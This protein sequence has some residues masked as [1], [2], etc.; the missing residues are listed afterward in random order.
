MTIST[1][2]TEAIAGVA[3]LNAGYTLGHADVAILKA[4]AA[5][6]LAVREAQPVRY[7]WREIGEGGWQDCD[8]ARYD[9]CN[10]M[11]ELD[12]RTI[13][14]P[15]APAVP[16]GFKLVPVEPTEDM[17]AAAMMC[18]DVKFNSDETFCVNFGNIYN[19]ALA[20]APTPTK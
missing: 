5:E 1:V 6:L 10:I 11:P 15:P 12:T 8:K 3:D 19:A 14:A 13:T 18:D 4:L 20:A 7:Q 17:I 16:A 2:P 9:Y